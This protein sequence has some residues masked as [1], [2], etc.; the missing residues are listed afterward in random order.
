MLLG[1]IQ[2]V[3]H[4]LQTQRYI[5]DLGGYEVAIP[6]LLGLLQSTEKKK[7]FLL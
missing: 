7:N 4:Q 2:K 1:D 6:W 3:R 5:V